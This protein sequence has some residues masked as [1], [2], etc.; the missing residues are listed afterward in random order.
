MLI[1]QRAFKIEMVN[2]NIVSKKT[3]KSGDISDKV[4]EER[5]WGMYFF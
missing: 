4:L 3:I 1:L 5:R 2:I